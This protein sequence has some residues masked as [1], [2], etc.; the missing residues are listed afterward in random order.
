MLRHM[1]FLEPHS[2]KYD[3]IFCSSMQSKRFKEF[4]VVRIEKTTVLWQHQREI[5]DENREKTVD[6]QYYLAALLACS[7]NLPIRR[8]QV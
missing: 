1:K 2:A 4:S 3:N 7:G 5:V 6:P 8:I